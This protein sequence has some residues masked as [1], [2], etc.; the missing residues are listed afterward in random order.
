MGYMQVY[1][2]FTPTLLYKRY[3]LQQ[4]ACNLRFLDKVN[5]DR[6]KFSTLKTGITNP[7]L[8][9]SGYRALSAS[10]PKQ[11]DFSKQQQPCRHEQEH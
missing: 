11:P 7:K 3:I 8:K 5:T 2:A 10:E 4:L 1:F 6:L 9:Q